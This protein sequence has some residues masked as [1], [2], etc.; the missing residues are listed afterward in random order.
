MYFSWAVPKRFR[1]TIFVETDSTRI[2]VG[3]VF[4]SATNAAPA[5]L[6]TLA[7]QYDKVDADDPDSS[8][9]DHSGFFAVL[10]TWLS[11][12]VYA[13]ERQLIMQS[14]LACT[15]KSRKKTPSTLVNTGLSNMKPARTSVYRLEQGEKAASVFL[16][17][18]TFGKSFKVWR[19]TYG[20]ASSRPYSGCCVAVILTQHG[21]RVGFPGDW[22][23]PHDT[24]N[25]AASTV[26]APQSM[27]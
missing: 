9:L 15:P 6:A 2:L 12:P 17:G 27:C 16:D 26:A 19:H 18:S 5:Q 20:A 21:K 22:G 23:R 3:I 10:Y 24:S 14:T 4:I 13:H 25:E 1:L 11:G 7:S 8:H